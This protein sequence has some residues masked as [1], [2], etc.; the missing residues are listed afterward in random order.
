MT[1][2]NVHDVAWSDNAIFNKKG[3]VEFSRSSFAEKENRQKEKFDNSGERYDAKPTPRNFPRRQ[4]RATDL[5][6]RN[7]PFRCKICD[8][9]CSYLSSQHQHE[10][11]HISKTKTAFQ[12]FEGYLK[13]FK[14]ETNRKNLDINK[15]G[16]KHMCETCGKRFTLIENLHRHQMIHTNERPFRCTHCA[17]SFRL[18]QH[19][20]EHIR[21]HTGEKPY[22]CHT[23]GHA[24][25]Q[26]SNLKSHQKT[27]TKI[28]GYRCDQCGKEFRRSFTLKQH[29]MIH[30]K[31]KKRDFCAK[32]TFRN[33]TQ[34]NEKNL[35]Y[36]GNVLLHENN[37]TNQQNNRVRENMENNFS[38][39]YQ[40]D[41]YDRGP[42]QNDVQGVM[43]SYRFG[44]HPASGAAHFLKFLK[45][46]RDRNGATMATDTVPDRA[47]VEPSLRAYSSG[48]S[49]SFKSAAGNVPMSAEEPLTFGSRKRFCR[50]YESYLQQLAKVNQQVS[51]FDGQNQNLNWN[52]FL[53]QRDTGNQPQQ[54]YFEQERH[55]VDENMASRCA[56][57]KADHRKHTVSEQNDV[58]S[59]HS[60]N[61]K[62]KRN[63][64]KDW[65][66]LSTNQHSEGPLRNFTA[67]EENEKSPLKK[68]ENED[69]ENELIKDNDPKR[70]ST[71]RQSSVNEEDVA[72]SPLSLSSSP[73][74]TCQDISCD[75]TPDSSDSPK[76]CYSP[77]SKRAGYHSTWAPP[78]GL[79]PPSKA[80]KLYSDVAF[81]L[82]PVIEWKPVLTGWKSLIDGQVYPACESPHDHI[83]VGPRPI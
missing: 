74:Q 56:T 80:T 25:C 32:R 11:C 33:Q 23:C 79:L 62:W 83:S 28:K 39:I 10:L 66:Q 76:I 12:D 26:I 19:L 8:K 70:R 45:K 68:G 16:K 61:Y 60:G 57:P 35:H 54:E 52:Q 24:F 2:A 53:K 4:H 1:P 3:A 17:K 15:G 29:K 41:R 51:L 30:N 9:A 46:N 58:S 37:P 13:Y 78:G 42:Q 67:V 7:K 75:L 44:D 22:K 27:H 47:D 50:S 34:A 49:Y 59:F 43:R 82:V 31:T 20:K 5:C 36:V 14:K 69:D 77:R 40:G 73:S 21:I 72:Y 65:S 64:F 81:P 48:D 71:S 63:L 38:A 55:L 6:Q 18:S